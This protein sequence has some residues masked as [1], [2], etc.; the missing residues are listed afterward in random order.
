[1]TRGVGETFHLCLRLSCFLLET[2]VVLLHCK[3][4]CIVSIRGT[5]EFKPYCKRV[6]EKNKCPI[7]FAFVFVMFTLFEI[8]GSCVHKFVLHLD[9]SI[10]NYNLTLR[11]TRIAFNR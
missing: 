2:N 9:V 10:F 8:L 7:S 1:M 5:V 6:V 4:V 11:V 3:P